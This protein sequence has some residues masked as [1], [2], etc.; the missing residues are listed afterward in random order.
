MSAE[1]KPQNARCA[2]QG[3]VGRLG[4]TLV[5]GSLNASSS[6][7]IVTMDDPSE[8]AAFRAS[9][10]LRQQEIGRAR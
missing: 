7:P 8:V 2:F 3:G 6:V 1:S 5:D 9:S 4:C 10:R